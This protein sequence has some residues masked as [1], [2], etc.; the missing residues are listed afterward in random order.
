LSIR[1]P[2][3][4]DLFRLARKRAR[5]DRN[6]K[7]PPKRMIT[8]IELMANAPCTCIRI[9]DPRGLFLTDHA[10]PTHN[11]KMVLDALRARGAE[12]VLIVC[13]NTVKA[14]W[15]D[16]IE[17]HAPDMLPR[18]LVLD[19]GSVAKRERLVREHT[20]PVLVVVNYESAWR[21]PLGGTLAG[22]RWDAV[23][24]D[25]S[26]RAKSPGA[27]CSRWA[28]KLTAGLKACLTGTPLPHSPLDAYGQYRFLDVGLL[29]SRFAA[30]RD[31]YAVMGGYEG[32]QIFGWRNQEE[33]RGRLDVLRLEITDSVLTLPDL[34]TVD[35]H[36]DLSPAALRVYQS[37]EQEFIAEVASG[38][39][40]VSNALSKL[41]RL[42]QIT[43]GYLKADDADEPDVVD[44]AKTDALRELLED[45]GEPVAV[46]ARFKHDLAETRTICQTLGL[47]YGEISGRANDYGAWRK[48]EADVLGVQVQSGS[49]GLNLTRARLL[50]FYSLG[51]SL[52]DYQ[53]AVARVHRPG[54]ERPVVIYRLLARGTVDEKIIKGLDKRS[55]VIESLLHGF[56]LDTV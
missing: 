23:I 47:R 1:Y 28:A 24:L 30:F 42:Q 33:L 48:G 3:P 2:E 16:E 26:H 44:S 10:I 15:R 19:K 17:T 14:V 27:K 53:Q 45:A 9:A 18:L 4:K 50:V 34:Q 6:I 39:V 41:L 36:V 38:V 31:R 40:T 46:F 22:E 5:A 55:G 7:Y 8:R 32:H 52:G 13:P 20:G 54:Q 12:R 51:Y 56:S 37:L 21:V 43:S 29:G 49:T 11:T 35:R 25:E